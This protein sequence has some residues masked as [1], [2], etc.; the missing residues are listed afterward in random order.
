MTFQELN[1]LLD[2][3]YERLP[4][5]DQIMQTGQYD[6]R[7]AKVIIDNQ[8]CI[9]QKTRV[10][11]EVQSYLE[12]KEFL[13]LTRFEPPSLW[14]NKMLYIDEDDS[15]YFGSFNEYSIYQKVN[16]IKVYYLFDGDEQIMAP[17]IQTYFSVC[18]LHAFHF[19]DCL[20][21][22]ESKETISELNK[23]LIQIVGNT[24][25]YYALTQESLFSTSKA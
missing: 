20:L 14:F 18:L 24:Q 2:E 1:Q 5:Y 23:R 4:T 8:L 11:F 13:D 6:F 19:I 22:H 17:D 7:Y 12:L 3:Y 15:I 10:S 16:D 9:K 25:D 21:D